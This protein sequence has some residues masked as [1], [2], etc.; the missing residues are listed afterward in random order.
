MKEL[1]KIEA[2]FKQSPEDFIVEEVQEDWSPKVSVEDNFNKV[3]DISTLEPN[4]SRSFL[5]CEFEKRNIDLFT[6]IKILASHLHKGSDSMGYA[7]IK[8]KKAHTIQRITIF[9]PDMDLIKTFKHPNIYLKNFK[10]EKRK[11]KMG[12]LYGNRFIITLRNLDKKDAI[13]HSS[14]LRRLKH[15]A[16]YFGKQR[17]GSVRG[18]NV[19]I[20]KLLV[21]RK[22][23]EVLETLL[24]DTSSKEQEEVTLARIKL[25]KEKDY[26]E[27]LNYFPEYLRFERRILEGL[28]KK[29][30][31][32]DIIK[33]L[34]RKSILMYVHSLQSHLFNI[35][36]ETSLAENFDFTQKGQQKIPLMGYR[37]KIED[38]P[39]KETEEKVLDDEGLVLDDFNILE[40]PYLRIK[41]D[42]RDALVPIEDLELELEDDEQND[43][44]KKIILQFTLKKGTY[45]TTFLENFFIL[46]D[47]KP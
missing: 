9:E 7:G 8:D 15:F 39:L 1:T 23:M 24:L 26:R 29:K 11:I 21:K 41:G 47:P 20:G 40:I 37:T 36:L 32:V 10:W 46:R 44:A 30:E 34:E 33:S 38:E 18:N 14:H 45:A 19:K 43:G 35:I 5:A 13:K 4:E 28:V 31:P 42:L 17:F 27:A 25:K 12:Y 2:V 6:A 22:F 3:P 16:N